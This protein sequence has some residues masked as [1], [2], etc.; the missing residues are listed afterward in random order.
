MVRHA[1][2]VYRRGEVTVL[3]VVFT[4]MGAIGVAFIGLTGKF[5]VNSIRLGMRNLTNWENWNELDMS[6][7]D[8][9]GAI[10]NLSDIMGEPG[11]RWLW[12]VDPW[13]NRSINQLLEGYI[14]YDDV[15]GMSH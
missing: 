9:G 14:S 5:C 6:K 1:I 15:L 2:E 8:R 13:P 4:I 11:C 3:A 12:P 10:A 7:L